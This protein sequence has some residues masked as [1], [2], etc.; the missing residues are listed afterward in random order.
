MVQI[1]WFWYTGICMELSERCIAQLEKENWLHIYEQQDK[2]GSAYPLHSHQHT[3]VILVTEG[4][5]T[6]T[7]N[8]MVQILRTGDRLDIPPATPHTIVAGPTGCQY[9]VGENKA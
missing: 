8:E 7:T 9:V 3:V 6:V 2:P 5:M 4:S 1:D